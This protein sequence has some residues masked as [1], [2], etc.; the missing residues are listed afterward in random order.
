MDYIEKEKKSSNNQSI[1]KKIFL[2]YVYIVLIIIIFYILSPF[3][4]EYI[5][6]DNKGIDG[7]GQILGISLI[8]N[9]AKYIFIFIFG[10]INP[11]RTYILNKDKI[12]K[13][14][15][16]VNKIL[17]TF[18]IF[19]P[20]I[21]STWIVLE[22]PISNYLYVSKY[23]TGEND[24]TINPE[25]YKKPIDFYNELKERN[26]LYNDET[27]ILMNRLNGNHN[28]N[29]YIHRGDELISVPCYA[30]S[31]MFG[32]TN[33]RF[34][35]SIDN[36]N[37]IDDLNQKSYPAYI[38]NAILTLPNQ[39]ED[40][41][42]AALGRYSYNS[43]DYGDYR[44]KFE[45][46]YIECKL[47]YVDEDIYAI[48]GVGQC[49]NIEKYYSYIRKSYQSFYTYPY[50]MIISEKDT[51]TTFYNDKY[52][53]NGA[54]ANHGDNFIMKPNT[55]S[56]STEELYNIKT[57]DKLDANTINKIAKELQNTTLKNSIEFH[58]NQKNK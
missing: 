2:E 18:I 6:G 34:Y 57:V 13:L 9:I 21:L 5:V 27:S 44:P 47:L 19:F 40:L 42:Y 38:Y 37:T 39:N 14:S 16:K 33:E 17:C 52:Y 32:L 23:E 8:L 45:D 12:K 55:N 25:N 41:Q 30:E 49:Y 56:S 26:L 1:K 54:I 10:V 28:S 11:I 20:I 58:F 53:P 35:D 51:I 7:I 48:L 50:Y 3:L 43:D 31:L 4:L 46:Y 29:N 36:E 24:Y 22:M 15:S